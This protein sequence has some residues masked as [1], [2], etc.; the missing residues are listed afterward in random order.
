MLAERSGDMQPDRCL[1]SKAAPLRFLPLR[2][3][4]GGRAAPVVAPPG[5]EPGTSESES[6][7]LPITPRGSSEGGRG[8]PEQALGSR[9]RTVPERVVLAYLPPGELAGATCGS[10]LPSIFDTRFS[11]RDSRFSSAGRR[12]L[13][14]VSSAC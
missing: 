12:F 13:V 3:R 1:F 6:D 5:L 7:V 10:S 11:S 4:Y 8:Y 14:S 2:F 9:S